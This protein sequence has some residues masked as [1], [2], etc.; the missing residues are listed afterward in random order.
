GS[1]P[2]A[3]LLARVGHLH[4]LL[5]EEPR[6]RAGLATRGV[7]Q[8][9]EVELNRVAPAPVVREAEPIEDGTA[10][11]LLRGEVERVRPAVERHGYPSRPAVPWWPGFVASA[12]VI[13]LSQP[14]VATGSPIR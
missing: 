7:A 12:L 5:R 8:V 3:G 1:V 4:S 2:P 6:P 14:G 11:S 13:L 9:V 10:F